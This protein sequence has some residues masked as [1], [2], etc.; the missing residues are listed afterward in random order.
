MEKLM[1]VGNSDKPVSKVGFIIKKTVMVDD[2]D[3][4]SLT[5]KLLFWN[6]IIIQGQQLGC[7]TELD[8]QRSFLEKLC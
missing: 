8:I 6:K 1:I 2:R 7:F 4:K 3:F 5:E